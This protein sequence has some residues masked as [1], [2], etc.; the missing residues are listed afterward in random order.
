MKRLAL[1]VAQFRLA[2]LGGVG[3]VQLFDL[4]DGIGQRAEAGCGILHAAADGG[5]EGLGIS[6][7]REALGIFRAKCY[8]LLRILIGWNGRHSSPHLK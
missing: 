8:V 2:I 7:D 5:A 6:L 3:I 1:P 4:H